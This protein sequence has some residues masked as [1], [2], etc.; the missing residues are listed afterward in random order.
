MEEYKYEVLMAEFYN[1]FG[2]EA[3]RATGGDKK[4]LEDGIYKAKIKKFTQQG[5]VVFKVK[6]V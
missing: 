1:L 2:F 3:L 4:K 5:V 6:A